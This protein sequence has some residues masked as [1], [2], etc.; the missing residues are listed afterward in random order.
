MI[1]EVICMLDEGSWLG[2]LGPPPDEPIIGPVPQ[3][4]AEPQN[5]TTLHSD[6]TY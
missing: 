5:P 4:P 3:E 2:G 6:R 1:E